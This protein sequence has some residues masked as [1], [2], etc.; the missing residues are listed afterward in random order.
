MLALG[1]AWGC[2]ARSTS[3]VRVSDAPGPPGHNFD[4]TFRSF[5]GSTVELDCHL[6]CIG[7]A[8]LVYYHVV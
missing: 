5:L 6:W 3:V 4:T 7:H 2:W 1:V 8:K